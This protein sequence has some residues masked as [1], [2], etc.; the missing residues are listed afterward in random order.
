MASIKET[1]EARYKLY[2]DLTMDEEP[3]TFEEWLQT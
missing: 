3:M 2:L 1:L